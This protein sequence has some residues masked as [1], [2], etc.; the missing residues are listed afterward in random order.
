MNLTEIE[1]Q[2]LIAY[3]IGA[4]S[5]GIIAVLTMMGAIPLI[6]CVILVIMITAYIYFVMR[7]KT[8]EDNELE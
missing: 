6:L 7:D 4:G 5:F 3:I 2:K 8:D 1:R